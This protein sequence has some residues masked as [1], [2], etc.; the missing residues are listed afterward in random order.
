[1]TLDAYINQQ[2]DPQ[3]KLTPETKSFGSFNQKSVQEN[4]PLL[5]AALLRIVNGKKKPTKETNASL[6]EKQETKSL[7]LRLAQGWITGENYADQAVEVEEIKAMNQA[8]SDL[9]DVGMSYCEVFGDES[10]AKSMS[11]MSP[12]VGRRSAYQAW[13]QQKTKA[14]L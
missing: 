9:A 5:M 1:M 10:T 11:N 3:V 14:I 4:N 2:K 13:A 8:F 6:I 7:A 12:T